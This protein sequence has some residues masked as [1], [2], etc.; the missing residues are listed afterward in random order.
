METNFLTKYGLFGRGE[1]NN[2]G[3]QTK[4]MAKYGI[5]TLGDS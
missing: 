4:K 1:W 5:K 2:H 3:T